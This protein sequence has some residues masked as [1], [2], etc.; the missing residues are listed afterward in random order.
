LMQIA[1]A[2]LMCALTSLIIGQP[3]FGQQP[4][5]TQQ[6]PPAPQQQQ[7]QAA[8]AA[9]PEISK[10]DPD[11]GEP[12]GGSYWLSRGTPKTLPGNA[13]Q[14][15]TQ[16]QVLGLPN[17]RPRSPGGFIS[18]PAG[19]FNHLEISY[20]QVDGN[21]T[22]Y[23]DTT[24]SLLGS[25]IPQGYFIST[26]YRIRNAEV[27]W[28]F[29]NWPVPPEDSKW[30]F[31]SLLSFDY[32]AISTTVDAPY[33]AS[34]SFQPAAG[35]TSIY[36][37]AFGIEAEYIPNKT[38][39]FEARTSGFGF[40]HHADIA[41]AEARVVVRYKHLEFFGEYKFFHF[42]TSPA[43]TQFFVGTLTGPAAGLRWIIR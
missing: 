8:T 26:S 24:L 36:Y 22:G 27:T 15:Y 7:N 37:P 1:T 11:Y 2:S 14:Y 33:D 17:A 40:P 41:D 19:K 38:F 13:A 16:E 3:L 21:G 5:P 34:T 35:T 32:T 20:F 28:N 25:T 9:P 6:E 31:R 12:D 39:Y 29:L 30:R 43:G 10:D 4:P 23:A 42:K 18:I